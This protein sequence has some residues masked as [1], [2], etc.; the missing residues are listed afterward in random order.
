MSISQST[1]G[2][3]HALAVTALIIG[4]V[5]I[6]LV[7]L[8]GLGILTAILGFILAVIARRLAGRAPEGARGLAT[9]GIVVNGVV[10]ALAVIVLGLV[11]VG[12]LGTLWRLT[13][14]T[15]LGPSASI[16]TPTPALSSSPSADGRTRE[17]VV[18]PTPLARTVLIGEPA[19]VGDLTLSA[20]G[21]IEKDECPHGGGRPAQAAKFL[22]V[23]ARAS[24]DGR[25][26]VD[27]STIHWSV[28]GY[29]AGLGAG[30]PCRYDQRAFGNACWKSSGK[31][32]PGAACEGW[33]L[34]EVPEGLAVDTTTIRAEV[35]QRSGTS[36]TVTWR[37]RQ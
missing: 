1:P 4:I 30:S 25:V 33:L 35:S 26:L 11:G 7:G 34:F 13:P 15:T 36:G 5:S 23:Q 16:E 24:N 31:L 14:P 18:L 10:L 29:V 19:K 3:A 27:L 32:F 37:I 22:V 20:L 8:C 12:T 6:P 9:A 28:D 2:Y 21:I 17:R